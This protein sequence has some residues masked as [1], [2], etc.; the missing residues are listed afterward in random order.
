V[1]WPATTAVNAGGAGGGPGTGEVDIV[2]LTNF[3]GTTTLTG[4]SRSCGLKLPDGILTGLGM[5]ATGGGTKILIQVPNATWDK[6]TRTFAV[7]GTQ[8]GFNIGDTLDTT[9]STGLLGLADSSGYGTPTAA[10]S[11]TW[12]AACASGTCLPAGSF[13]QS[14]LQ[15][16]DNDGHPGIT[17][18]P[19]STNGYALPP[20]QAILAPVANQV[21]IVS[22]NT[23]AL[24]GM[25]AVDCTHGTGTAKITSFDNHVVG[26]TTICPNPPPALGCTTGT[27]VE[28]CNSDAVGF[29]DANRTIYGYDQT[30]G[31]LISPT[32]PVTGTVKTVQIAAGSSCADARA[33]FGTTFN[34]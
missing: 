29:L 31:D 25:H 4:T 22:R 12:P 1:G 9:A 8:S 3:T 6:I 10:P 11:K 2:L 7:T 23:I 34:Q 18:I 33:Q 14:D 28:A 13:M 24:S 16:D 19:A 5:A 32:H 30:M 17:A 20:T 21:F 27:T 26:C 15:D